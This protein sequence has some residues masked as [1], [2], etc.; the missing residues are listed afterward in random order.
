MYWTEGIAGLMKTGYEHPKSALFD[1]ASE[2]EE[3]FDALPPMSIKEACSRIESL[4]GLKRSMTQVRKF[5]NQLGFRFLRMGHIPAKANPQAQADFLNQTLQPLIEQAKEGIAVLLFMDAAHFVLEP[6]VTSVWC[7]VRLFLR[8]AAGRNRINVLGALNPIS[9]EVSTYINETY[10]TATSICEFLVQI[11]AQYASLSCPIHIVLDNAR[12]QHCKLVTQMA[13]EMGIQLHFL[14]P[15]SPN[16]NL[17]ER[18]WKFT[19]KNVLYG[20]Y[21]PDPDAFHS[22]IKGF[23]HNLHL[24]KGELKPL[25]TLNFQTFDYAQDLAA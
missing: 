21:F 9:L 7:K 25:L 12:Y 19:K 3:D 13:N 17:I 11:R 24:R 20:K 4:T 22:A 1:Y 14:P 6:F 10:I 8:A 15:Y 16:L 2:I 23:M 5:M 18:L